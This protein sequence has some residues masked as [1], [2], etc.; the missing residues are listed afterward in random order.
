MP[1]DRAR[2]IR[3][4]TLLVAL[5]AAVSAL[6]FM[7]IGARGSWSFVLTHRGI[8]LAALVTVA[9]AIALSTVLFQTLTGNRI[10]TPAVM[11]F[12]ALFL[13]L[14]TSLVAF[15]GGAGAG[16]LDPRLLFS[17]EC[18]VMIGL[19]GF[20]FRLLFRGEGR[21]LALVVL[22]GL[23]FGALFRSLSAF[24]QRVMDPNDFMVLQGRTFASFNAADPALIGI[25]AL[26]ALTVTGLLLPR[27][28][29][30]DV[31]A[32]GRDKATGLG[33]DTAKLSALVFALV[34]I[35]VSASTAL[36]GP[37]TFFGL[38]VANLAYL[39]VPSA[40]HADVLPIAVGLAIITLVGGQMLLE[41]VLGF[42]T[43]LSI[44]I[45]FIGGIAFLLIL[46]KTGRR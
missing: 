21:N 12:D 3:R 27:L 17:I 7:T 18:L 25:A 28:P 35:L 23:L 33:I 37:T 43:A 30:L 6:A 34:A 29:E 10:L 38:L 13:L 2:A 4:L 8:R 31:L 42:G 46:F 5:L 22:A 24:L 40:R 16:A 44:V 14:Q 1:P 45:D 11:G 20:L 41:R 32:L 39:L 19:S 15:L 36:V 9:Y 26:L